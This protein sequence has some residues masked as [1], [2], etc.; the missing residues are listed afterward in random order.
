[1]FI[2]HIFAKRNLT[3]D[4]SKECISIYRHSR[5]KPIRKCF[6]KALLNSLPAKIWHCK[7]SLSTPATP[8]H[9]HLPYHMLRGL[10]SSIIC[11]ELGWKTTQRITKTW[12]DTL[13]LNQHIMICSN[14]VVP[15]FTVYFLFFNKLNFILL[16]FSVFM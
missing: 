11:T 8:A 1:M 16:K 14:A 15:Q 3:I 4:I 13:R 6:V 7:Y 12:K 9:G 2:T 10:Y 5:S